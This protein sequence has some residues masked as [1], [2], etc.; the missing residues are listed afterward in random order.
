M[1][2]RAL[3]KQCGS[4]HQASGESWGRR[5][6]A[7]SRPLG[8]R[9]MKDVIAFRRFKSCQD[10]TIL[11]ETVDFVRFSFAINHGRDPTF[12]PCSVKEDSVCEKSCEA[13]IGHTFV[14]E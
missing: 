3:L 13:V 7:L 11:A 10:L 4:G 5:N 12:L 2:G 1:G 8:R 9:D 14:M 6:R